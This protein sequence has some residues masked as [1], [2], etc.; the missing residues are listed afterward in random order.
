MLACA[1]ALIPPRPKE[2]ESSRGGAC[3]DAK[4]ADRALVI[5]EEGA[6]VVVGIVESKARLKRR[7]RAH[8]SFRFLRCCDDDLTSSSPSGNGKKSTRFAAPLSRAAAWLGIIAEE[9]GAEL[10]WLCPRP[11]PPLLILGRPLRVRCAASSRTTRARLAIHGCHIHG[12]PART[13]MKHHPHFRTVLFALGTKRLA[14]G[15]LTLTEGGL[16]SLPPLYF[17]GCALMRCIVLHSFH[18]FPPALS[19]DADVV[20]TAKIKGT[21]SA[22]QVSLFGFWFFSWRASELIGSAWTAM[23]AAFAALHPAAAFVSTASPATFKHRAS[24]SDASESAA[25]ESVSESANPLTRRSSTSAPTPPPSPAPPHTRAQRAPGLRHAPRT[26]GRRALR[27]VDIA[28][29]R[30]RVSWTLGHHGM[31]ERIPRRPRTTHPAAACTPIVCPV[32]EPLSPDLMSSVALTGTNHAEGE[33][34]YLRVMRGVDGPVLSTVDT[35]GA[36][37]NA[38]EE[39]GGVDA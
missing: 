18:F 25:S 20:N 14:Y 32:F 29:L 38:V 6:G 16:Q 27:R 15:A 3:C 13:R 35:Q 11:P 31:G 9:L 23:L 26:R 37:A 10:R 7:S 2:I 30:G 17:P 12:Q 4:E 8:N 36:K 5:V 21:H 19:A 1:A 39:K 22:T 24:P 28:M 34:V 33:A